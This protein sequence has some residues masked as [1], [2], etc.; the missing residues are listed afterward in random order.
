MSNSQRGGSITSFAKAFV[1]LLIPALI[2][3]AGCGGDE[4]PA[5]TPAPTAGEVEIDIAHGQGEM[6]GEATAE[7]VILQSRLTLKGDPLTGAPGV[8]RFEVS[9]S[10]VF[11]DSFLTDWITA[12]AGSDFMIKEKVSGLE[13]G[14]RYYYRL[15]YGEEENALV[16]GNTCTFRTLDGPDV[17]REVS[18][19]VVTGMNYYKFQVFLERPDKELGYPA[20]ETILGMNPDFFVGT[21][22][23]IYYDAFPIPKVTQAELRDT[24]HMQFVQPRYISLF[25]QVP[26]YWEKDDHDFRY[27]DADPYCDQGPSAELGIETFLEQVPVAD[28]DKTAQVTYRTH[29]INEMLQIWLVE[30]RDYR[31]SNMMEDG[32]GKTI[33]GEAQKEW[34]K[35]TLLESDATFKLLI[36]PTPMIGPDESI[37]SWPAPCQDEYKRDN[38]TNPRGFKYEGEAFFTCEEFSCG[39]LIDANSR[40]GVSPGDPDSSDPEGLIEQPFTDPVRSGGFL[41]VTVRPDDGAGR[42]TCEFTFY[43][44]NGVVLYSVTRAAE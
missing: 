26:T 24:W 37:L 32:P 41:E 16:T 17:A 2:I 21:G 30:N 38:H 25:S 15:L 9:T 4:T 42:E 7:S 35:Q 18:F 29:R 20:L 36:S 10:P 19:A 1:L 6:A 11:D 14:T 22:D 12:E 5:A 23:N 39:A 28:P 40:V 33:W 8:A 34:L 3:C 31:S 13:P 44:E 43:D 27:N